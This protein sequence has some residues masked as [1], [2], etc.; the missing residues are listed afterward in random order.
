MVSIS[1]IWPSLAYSG[2]ARR[3]QD[4]P[5]S[6]SRRGL[7]ARQRRLLRRPSLSTITAARKRRRLRSSSC[8]TLL[9]T[10]AA[11]IATRCD[12]QPR[13]RRPRTRAIQRPATCRGPFRGT[14]ARSPLNCCQSHR[15]PTTQILRPS[16][17][18]NRAASLTCP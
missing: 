4:R 13:L 7:Q 17:V 9:H 12:T 11:N 5:P 18:L 16:L 8:A 2:E 3:L 14:S 10:L 15:S 1:S 6:A